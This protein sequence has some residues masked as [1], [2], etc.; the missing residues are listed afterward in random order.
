MCLFPDENQ[1]LFLGSHRF[2]EV[3]F[4]IGRETKTHILPAK[5]QRTKKSLTSA[6]LATIIL[7]E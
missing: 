7:L 5:N 4:F 1:Q 6:S 2:S 3:T